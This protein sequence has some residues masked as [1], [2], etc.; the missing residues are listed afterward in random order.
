MRR[1][2][3][4][5]SDTVLPRG[6]LYGLPR[7]GWPAFEHLAKEAD[8][9]VDLVRFA[10]GGEIPLHD[11]PGMTGVSACVGGTLRISSFDRAGEAGR[12]TV[13]I[14][15][16]GQRTLAPGEASSFTAASGNVHRVWADAPARLI[17]VF[18]PPYGSPLA[19]KTT[20]YRVE[21][22]PAAGRGGVLVASAYEPN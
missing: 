6:R 4:E 18:T 9:E 7:G 3:P 21:D 13:L 1:L 8:F 2:H 19:G 15:D 22:A 16:L 17:D 10:A 20:W 5:D 14:R 12:G 11:H